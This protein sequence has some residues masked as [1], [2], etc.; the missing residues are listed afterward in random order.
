MKPG[1]QKMYQA[2]IN[3][4]R[5][6]FA[7]C[8]I[9]AAGRHAGDFNLASV[10]KNLSVAATAATCHRC[11]TAGFPHQRRGVLCRGRNRPAAAKSTLLKNDFRAACRPSTGEISVEGEAVDQ[12]R[13]AIVGIV[14]QNSLGCCHGRKHSSATSLLP[15]DMKAAARATNILP[16]ANGAIEAGW[17]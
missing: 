12:N 1:G 7:S 2:L 17:A 8:P 5:N 4:P 9:E 3:R 6:L 13:T 16:R 14:F 10:S 15:I 11:K